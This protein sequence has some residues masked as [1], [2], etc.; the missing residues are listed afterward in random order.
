M[1]KR[2]K[3]RIYHIILVSN[4]KQIKTLYNCASEIL[5]NKKFDELI[6]N[7][8][9]ITDLLHQRIE[10][11]KSRPFA[12]DDFIEF[13]SELISTTPPEKSDYIQIKNLSKSVT[14]KNDC[15]NKSLKEIKGEKIL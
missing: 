9:R 7:N 8:D 6:M 4:G 15:S 13:L 12:D 2:P 3:K 1:S 11:I 5:I 10:Y 14:I